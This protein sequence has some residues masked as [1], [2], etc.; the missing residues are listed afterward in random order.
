MS[1]REVRIASLFVPPVVAAIASGRGIEPLVTAAGPVLIASWLVMASALAMRWLEARRPIGRDAGSPWRQVDVLTATGAATMWLGAGALI[2]AVRV[3]WASL[4]VVGVLGIATVEIVAA[5]TAIAAGGAGRWRGATVA[6]R[7]VPEIAVENDLVREEIELAGVH[8][9]IGMRLFAI[10]R[11]FRHGRLSRYAVPAEI[12]GARLRLASDLGPAP[13]GDHHVPPLALWFA[14]VLGLTRSAPFHLGAARC[15]V[16]PKPGKLDGARALLGHGRDEMRAEPSRQPTEGSLRIREYQPGD[17]TRRIHWVRSLQLDQLVVR[18]PDEIPLGEPDVRLLI[19]TEL[20]GAE[21]PACRAVD[22]LLDAMVRVWLG[23]AREL[24]ATGA[25]VVLAV[26]APG[27]DGRPIPVEQPYRARSPYDGLRL[28]ARVAWQGEIPID[29]LFARTPDRQV[30][31][32]Y[33][34]RRTRAAAAWVV[35]PEDAWTSPEPQVPKAAIATL[36]YPTGSADNRRGRVLAERRRIEAMCQ[37]R[38]VFSQITCWTDW[39]ARSG[40]FI[41]RPQGDRIAMAVI[42]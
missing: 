22:D 40:D 13:R 6:R 7:I 4:A 1:G 17:D 18:L 42:P 21:T 5:W 36:P 38:A 19:D 12:S 41:A 8:V 33:R 2:A 23:L 35:L 32:S 28:G 10:G 29:T 30:V 14:D 20:V 24:D 9:P 16:L 11:A 25:R 34:A 31:V 26:V 15:C 27:D 3:G 39:G 37:D